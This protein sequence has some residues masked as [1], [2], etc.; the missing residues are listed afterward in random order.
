MPSPSIAGPAELIDFP[1]EADGHQSNPEPPHLVFARARAEQQLASAEGLVQMVLATRLP[2]V[3]EQALQNIHVAINA[4]ELVGV[5]PVILAGTKRSRLLKRRKKRRLKPGTLSLFFQKT[6]TQITVQLY[7]EQ[8][9]MRPEA[10][11][12]LCHFL[13]EPPAINHRHHRKTDWNPWV[14]YNP[15]LFAVL[16]YISHQFDRPLFVVSAFRSPKKRSSKRKKNYHVRGRALDFRLHDG[17]NR[18]SSRQ[19]V[20]G[21]MESSFAHIGSGWYPNS[22]FVHLDVREKPSYYW[23]DPS[24]PGQRQ[25]NRARPIKRKPR[26]RADPTLNTVHISPASL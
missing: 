13:T 22:P 16:F 5:Y 23:T 3:R 18:V 7:D 25:R 15:R 26:Y 11:V 9:R 19:K 1:V 10:Y 21:F 12:R 17:R 24:G 14:A 2:E 4:A 6:S 8:G 20:L